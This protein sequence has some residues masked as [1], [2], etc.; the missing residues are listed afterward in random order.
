M[1][2]FDQ[3]EPK[4]DPAAAAVGSCSIDPGYAFL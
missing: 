1:T 2:V 3:K 4:K